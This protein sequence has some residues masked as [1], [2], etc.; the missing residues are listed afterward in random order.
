MQTEVM[1]VVIF[2]AG[3]VGAALGRHIADQGHDVWFIESNPETVRKLRER[4]DV[5][6]VQG[7][8][9][10]PETL[11]EAGV[12]RA[13]LI[14]VVTN[15]DKTNIIL[16]LIAR[17]LNPSARIILRVKGEEYL[18]N[19]LLWKS[20]N[21]ADTV[22]IS[23][24]HS[25][26]DKAMAILEVQQA[27]DVAEFADG[28]IR[29]AGFRLEEGSPLI[30]KPLR[31]VMPNYDRRILVVAA[32]RDGQVFT[33]KGSS[34]LQLGDRVFVT[35]LAAVDMD[36][37]LSLFGKTYRHNPKFVLA[38]GSPIGESIARE[39][40]H[41]GHKPVLLEPDFNRCRELA[42]L[43]KHTVVLHGDVADAAL[44]QRI[45]DEDTIFL[46]VTTSQEVNFLVSML[47]RKLGS[48]R[49]IT[50]MDNEAYL[51]MA[52]SLGVDA[53]LSPRISAVGA[54]LRYV[55]MGR[56]LDSAMLLDGQINLLLA[57]VEPRSHLDG[58]AVRQAS[59]PPGVLIAAAIHNNRAVV[60]DG[61]MVLH[62]GDRVLLATPM[63][64][65]LSTLDELIAPKR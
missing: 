27:F 54:I 25:V 62:A 28:E 11:Q 60:P 5:Q 51:A 35:V 24:E 23:P 45:I 10:D 20:A 46:S 4:Y 64:K 53:V 42:G 36:A 38:G 30:G 44:L 15:L 63:L 19:K 40:E 3:L 37:L 56:I 43:M 55:R 16:T 34:V 18:N 52:P 33:P 48:V 31:E 2:G 59:F 17:S 29:V 7:S 1:H 26:I 61:D 57:E 39:L 6:I 32:D 49:A 14:L 41:R 50:M 12:S 58:I 22:I 65:S 47:S 13:D 9:E 21:L 8:A